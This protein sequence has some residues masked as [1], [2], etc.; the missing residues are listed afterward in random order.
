MSV[1]RLPESVI[2]DEACPSE[3]RAGAGPRLLAGGGVGSSARGAGVGVGWSAWACGAGACG[4]GAC[5]AGACGAG[6]CGAGPCGAGA[7]GMGACGMGAG[8]G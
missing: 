3:G 8:P 2:V 5:G 4:A 7:C 1:L 6:A